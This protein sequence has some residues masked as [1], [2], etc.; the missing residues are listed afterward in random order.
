MTVDPNKFQ[1]NTTFGGFGSAE[2]VE[3][4]YT[5]SSQSI[6][7]ASYYAHP[8]QWFDVAQGNTFAKILMQIA[9]IDLCWREPGG[10]QFNSSNEY[11]QMTHGGN[12]ANSQTKFNAETYVLYQNGRIGFVTFLVNRTLPNAGITTPNITM[13]FRA[14]IYNRDSLA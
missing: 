3:N 1:M 13:N 8:V 14:Y 7:S 4:S 5:I 10:V 12:I 2:R 11:Y 9:P 6:A